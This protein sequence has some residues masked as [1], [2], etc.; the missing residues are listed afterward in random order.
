MQQTST[1]D[2][3]DQGTRVAIASDSGTQCSDVPEVCCGCTVPLT[4]PVPCSLVSYVCACVR[5]FIFI[6]LF[7]PR[8]FHNHPP[9]PPPPA[10]PIYIHSALMLLCT[11]A[12]PG[13][14]SSVLCFLV[15]RAFSFFD[16]TTHSLDAYHS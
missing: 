7:A 15:V 2:Y 4:V 14:P 13:Q 10:S 6:A 12:K 11:P 1:N 3:G 9:P 8:H 5:V 16:T